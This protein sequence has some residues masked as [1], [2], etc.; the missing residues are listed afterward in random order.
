[1]IAG[2]TLWRRSR[3]S[4]QAVSLSW[5]QT[6]A[7]YWSI[8]W[9]AWIGS[10]AIVAVFT[11]RYSV[12]ELKEHF[13]AV[14]LGG[15]LAFFAVQAVLI[16]RLVKKNYRTFRISV[17]RDSGESDRR[18]SM[19]E[20]GLVWLWVLW[21]QVALL[22]VSSLVALW[23][24]AKLDSEGVRGISSVSLWLRFLVVGPYAVGP[25]LKA[26]YPGFRLQA[27]GFRYS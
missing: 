3:Q 17:V 2:T 20:S 15:N 25:A 6:I 1:V 5:G 27:R 14:A 26:R 4:P 9:S 10:L 7:G 13:S 12:E 24:G 21:P 11:S 23:A 19:K 22:L 16:H 18:L 8:F